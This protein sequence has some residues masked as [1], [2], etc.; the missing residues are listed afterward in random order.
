MRSCVSNS[1]AETQL[2]LECM[3]ISLFLEDHCFDTLPMPVVQ[4][5]HEDEEA[6][7]SSFEAAISE[8]VRRVSRKLITLTES[9]GYLSTESLVPPLT[10]I[11]LSSL[12]NSSLFAKSKR[13]WLTQRRRTLLTCIGF[14]LIM[15]GFDGMGLLIL[16]LHS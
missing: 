3:P 15:I 4:A 11:K 12:Q 7:H 16:R 10:E 2:D 1:S 13:F 9:S 6:L 5:S 8:R 14:N